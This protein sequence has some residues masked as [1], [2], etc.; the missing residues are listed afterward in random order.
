M[1]LETGV[2]YPSQLNADWP[3][4]ADTRRDGDAHIRNIKTALKNIS[5][6]VGGKVAT[7]S[8]ME[9]NYPIGA[10]LIGVPTYNSNPNDD[11]G[12]YWQLLGKIAI[13]A[14]NNEAGLPDYTELYAWMRTS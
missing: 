8:L 9:H 14:T 2:Q 10:V 11:L 4:G 5:V 3:T 12:G 13:D 6:M 7:E 1:G